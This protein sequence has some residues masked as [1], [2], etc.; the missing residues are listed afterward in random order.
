MIIGRSYDALDELGD[1]WY[2]IPTVM[3][4][5]SK[6]AENAR[7]KSL[8]FSRRERNSLGASSTPQPLW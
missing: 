4:G 5:R 6:G 3:N 1:L 8:K 7:R 2:F